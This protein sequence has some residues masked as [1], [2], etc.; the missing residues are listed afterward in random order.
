MTTIAQLVE[1]HRALEERLDALEAAIA[2][3]AAIPENL[4]PAAELAREHY[5]C[6]R[7]FLDC[8]AAYQPNVAAKLIAQ[9]EEACE[10]AARF[11]E[12]HIAGQ[13]RDMLSL[14]R[15]FHAIAQ[16]NIIEEERDVFPLAHRCFTD[17][18]TP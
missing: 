13:T 3:G 16:H 7:P 14:A 18:Q 8:L 4:M 10:I 6:E 1:E 15:R 2:S 9:H 5:S 17:R 11:E 12:A